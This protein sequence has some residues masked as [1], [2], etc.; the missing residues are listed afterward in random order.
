M[1]LTTAEKH[2]LKIAR[3]TLKLSEFGARV[4]GGMNHDEARAIIKRLTGK[5]APS[6]SV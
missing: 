5:D 4:M 3:E 2:Q 6:E 1:R